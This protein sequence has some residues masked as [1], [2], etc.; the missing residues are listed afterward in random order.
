MPAPTVTMPKSLT[1]LTVY[2]PEEN[3]DIT[4]STPTEGDVTFNA[5]LYATLSKWPN[6]LSEDSAIEFGSYIAYADLVSMQALLPTKAR[7]DAKWYMHRYNAGIINGL[8]TTAGAPVLHWGDNLQG[9]GRIVKL[10]GDP[11][12]EV[13][14]FPSTTAVTTDFIL[15]GSLRLAMGFGERRQ[16]VIANS[17][18]AGF[19]A[20]QTW[21]RSTARVAIAA[22]DGGQL[23]RARTSTT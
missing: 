18:E 10:L 2:Y 4:E 22:K 1:E 14:V 3:V 7:A 5:R 16:L 9:T 17:Q 8:V 20:D 19:A 15:Y 21:I 12:I 11:L 6:T 23:V 13:D